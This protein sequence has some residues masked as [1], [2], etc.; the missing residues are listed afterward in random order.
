[1]TTATS[2]SKQTEAVREA[3]AGVIAPLVWA[4]GGDLYVVRADLEVVALHLS[5]RF[6]GCPGNQVLTREVLTPA[7]RAVAPDAEVRVSAG[8]LVPEGAVAVM[9]S[10]GGRP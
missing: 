8:P 3:I 7:I 4:D 9:P 10:S 6:S 5:G 1:M 2:H